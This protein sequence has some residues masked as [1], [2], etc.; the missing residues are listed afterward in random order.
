M[1]LQNGDQMPWVE[2]VMEKHRTMIAEQWVARLLGLEE[3]G[4]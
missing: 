3:K 1:Q 4:E 2:R